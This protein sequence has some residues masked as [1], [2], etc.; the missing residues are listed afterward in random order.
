L[1]DFPCLDE[2]TRK[3]DEWVEKYLA[4]YTPRH[5]SSNKVVKDPVWGMVSLTP[6]EITILDSPLLQR[7]RRIHQTGL[8]FLTYP[9]ALHTRFD[10]SVGMLHCVSLIVDTI[11]RKYRSIGA[12]AP[13]TELN[14]QE[15]RLAALL[16]DIGHAAL[17]HLTEGIFSDYSLVSGARKELEEH[18]RIQPK[19][20]ELLSAVIVRTKAFLSMLE[21]AMRANYHSNLRLEAE[22]AVKHIADMIIGLPIDNSDNSNE[23][24]AYITE[25]INGPYDADKLD[26]T[27]RDSYFTGISLGT[28]AGKFIAGLSVAYVESTKRKGNKRNSIVLDHNAISSYDQLIMSKVALYSTVYNHQKVLATN[29]VVENIMHIL[30]DNPDVEIRGVSLKNPIN[31]L[32]LSDWDFLTGDTKSDDIKKLQK[33]IE[34]RDLP[35]RYARISRLSVKGGEL[36]TKI[37]STFTDPKKIEELR[38]QLCRDLG[39]PSSGPETISIALPK[40]PRLG[41][42]VDAYCKQYDGSIE[43]FNKLSPMNYFQNYS[44]HKWAGYIFGPY[45]YLDDEKYTKVQKVL[46]DK[47]GIELTMNSRPKIKMKENAKWE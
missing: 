6:L 31:F 46:L 13:F 32:T 9:A 33:S 37:I 17:S 36:N 20:H 21:Q 2:L 44:L 8:V 43:R 4:D 28:D 45:K 14:E 1:A 25:L 15:I 22:S 16:H 29:K 30:R 27:F 3:M 26:Y 12:Q 35:V 42:L 47:L 18:K 34:N 10:H 5:I 19:N 7:L 39:L 24:K 40:P 38:E 23:D 41:E 11:N